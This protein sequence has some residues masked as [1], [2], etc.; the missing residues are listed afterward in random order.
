MEDLVVFELRGGERKTAI[1]TLTREKSLNSLTLDTINLLSEKVFDW[2]ADDTIACIVLKSSTERAFC[3]GAD[4]TAL[5]HAIRGDDLAHP[6]AFF[7]NEYRLD[8]ALHT[9]EKPILVWGGGVVMGGGL[10]LLAGCSH[11]IGTPD[12]RIAMPEITIGLFPDAGGTW[13]LSQ[14]PDHLGVFAGL[15]G[16]QLTAG[17]AQQLGMLDYV[18]AHDQ[19]N[20]VIDALEAMSWTG[21]AIKDRQLLSHYL[22]TLVQEQELPTNLMRRRADIAGLVGR[23]YASDDFFD[24]FERGLDEL[25]VDEWLA[26]A[27]ATYR[28]GSPTTARVFLE[29]LQRAESMT[30][31]ETFRMELVIAMQCSRH[32][33][34][35]EGVRALLVDK[36]KNP[37]WAFDKTSDVPDRYVEAHFQPAWQGDHPLANL[38]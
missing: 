24:T 9:A 2:L 35:P 18:L 4:I 10:G 17:D 37:T 23:A 1:A 8:H 5:Y 22:D 33:D 15:T 6:D 20:T 21:D 16:C 12:N 28:N 34:F 32:P 19:K 13:L 26:G 7:T 31:A 11:R 25:P 29:Q 3:A 27:I 38:L 36:D 14:M 30:L